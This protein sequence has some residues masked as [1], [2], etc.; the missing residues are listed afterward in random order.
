MGKPVRIQRKRVKGWVSPPNTVYVGR[1]G[2]YGNP[3]EVDMVAG[4]GWGVFRHKSNSAMVVFGIKEQALGH[5]LILYRQHL[6]ATN[7]DFGVLRGKNL[8]CFCKEGEPCHA[9]VLLELANR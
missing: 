4:S 1:P 9:D 7:L 2:K 3:Y 6:I 5:C 8:S